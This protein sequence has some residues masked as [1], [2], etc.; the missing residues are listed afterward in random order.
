M[1]WIVR[2]AWASAPGDAGKPQRLK[3]CGHF[4]QM[5]INV[6]HEPIACLRVSRG[7]LTE[8]NRDVASFALYR[9]RVFSRI[10]RDRT[11][12]LSIAKPAICA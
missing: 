8:Q 11:I 2:K 4:A 6:R 1:P 10:V 12:A 5:R 9:Q 3:P 7:P